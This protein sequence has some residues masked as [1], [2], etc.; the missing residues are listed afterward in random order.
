MCPGMLK[1]YHLVAWK[2][3]SPCG[4]HCTPHGGRCWTIP[5]E[6]KP[7]YVWLSY[8]WCSQESA[9]GP[10]IWAGQTLSC[11]GEVVWAAAEGIHWLMCH[12]MP[13]LMPWSDFIS[14]TLVRITV[15]GLICKLKI[16]AESFFVLLFVCKSLGHWYLPHLLIYK[17]PSHNLL[18][19]IIFKMC[20]M[21]C[22][23]TKFFCLLHLFIHG[24]IYS[25]WSL[26]VQL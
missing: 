2:S 9:Q 23:T 11:D 13:A 26:C 1:R 22:Y 24:V 12:G 14:P 19:L 21:N 25:T 8:V 10:Q 7:V 20:R 5:I 3:L 17:Q 4:L 18:I 16:L 15:M 6:P